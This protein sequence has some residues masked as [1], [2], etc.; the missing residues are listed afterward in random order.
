MRQ[1]LALFVLTLALIRVET[2][3]ANMELANLFEALANNDVPMTNSIGGGGSEC[4]PLCNALNCGT[5]NLSTGIC[6]STCDPS[7]V[8]LSGACVQMLCEFPGNPFPACTSEFCRECDESTGTC[9]EY[10]QPGQACHH[11]VCAWPQCEDDSDCGPCNTCEF[12]QKVCFDVCQPL[13]KVCRA[14]PPGSPT[15]YTCE[16][17]QCEPENCNPGACESCIGLFCLS[18]CGPQETC[19]NGECQNP[20]VCNHDGDCESLGLCYGCRNGHCEAT[21][22]PNTFP[23][24]SE[25]DTCVCAYPCLGAVS[26]VD[27]C[28]ISECKTCGP[29][30]SCTSTCNADQTCCNGTC[31]SPGQECVN[32]QCKAVKCGEL[33][34]NACNKKC[35][36]DV[37]FGGC[38]YEKKCGTENGACA[39]GCVKKAN[40]ADGTSAGCNCPSIDPLLPLS[41]VLALGWLGFVRLRRRY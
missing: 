23:M 21:C 33:A 24:N 36:S 25:P 35:G 22:P 15:P 9:R 19:V 5:C 18:N 17:A 40:A 29:N 14:A 12:Y 6:S 7:E 32:G 31:C 8:C 16:Y 34:L 20:T 30:G 11:G 39:C 1:L 28:K 2:T 41:V 37:K 4:G 27:Y 3:S 13:G 26:G 10:C 38:T